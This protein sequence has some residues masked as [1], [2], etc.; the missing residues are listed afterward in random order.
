[1]ATNGQSILDEE[2]FFLSEGKKRVRKSETSLRRL[3]MEGQVA[4]SGRRVMLESMKIET[5]TITS[6]QALRRFRERLN[7]LH[8]KHVNCESCGERRNDF[9]AKG[10]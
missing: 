1:M 3:I 2:W 8:E 7:E 9:C 10:H 5:G 6:V 4:P